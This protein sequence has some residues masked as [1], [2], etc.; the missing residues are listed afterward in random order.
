MPVAKIQLPDGRVGR[1]EV[2]EGTTPEQVMEFAN[3][4]FSGKRQTMT[5]QEPKID[6]TGTTTQRALAGV[7]K[8]FVDT[9]QGLKQL[10]AQAGNK[11]GL[12]DDSTVQAI[13]A[14]VDERARLDKPLMETGAGLTG[15][16]LGQVGPMFVPGAALGKVGAVKN[17]AAAVPKLAPF[18]GAAASGGGFSAA[19]PVLSGDSRLENAG[20]GALTGAVGQGAAALAGKVAS[21]AKDAISPQVRALAE[22]AERRGIPVSLAQLS[23][24]GFLKQLQSVIE[25]L[26]FTGAAGARKRQEQAFTREVSKTFGEN[27]PSVTSDV[28]AGAKARIGNDF[29]TLTARNSLQVD[30]KLMASLAGTIDESNRFATDETGRAVS[31]IVDEFLS[32]ADSSSI[33]P[34]KAYQALDSKLGKL[35]KSGGEKAYY[36]GEVRNAIRDAMDSSIGPADQAAWQTAR[37]QYRDLKTIRDLVYKE[38]ADGRISP[39]LLMGRLG[40]NNAGK[41]SMATGSRGELGTLGQ[42][43]R[44]FVRDP[45]PDSGTANRLMIQSALG[46]GAVGGGSAVGIDPASS[47]KAMILAATLGRGANVA[48]NNRLL[49]NYMMNG[50]PTVAANPLRAAGNLA[51]YALPA[52]YNALEQ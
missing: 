21:G 2:P 12:V 18:V 52:T 9:Y 23:D 43:G 14:D 3:Q 7:G 4:Q 44:Q 45:I 1:F 32:K 13:Q 33:V 37:K 29:E 27:T 24:S 50:L 20:Y 19:Q 46:L 34:G 6:P 28:Y 38:G 39:N 36:L 48:L 5:V 31:N 22:E 42:I 49:R 51:P 16:I 35:S 10:G 11:I 15:N 41:E 8:S 30:N 26:P 25:K 17:L 40:A 47:I